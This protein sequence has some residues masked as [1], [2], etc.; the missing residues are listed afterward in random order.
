MIRT[1]RS[2]RPTSSNNR[3]LLQELR[4]RFPGVVAI[5]IV[6]PFTF[7]ESDPLPD[8][9][10]TPV[11]V[12]GVVAK[13]MGDREH[14]PF[15][16]SFLGDAGHGHITTLCPEVSDDIKPFHIPSRRTFEALFDILHDAEHIAS[17]LCK[18][19]V[20]LSRVPDEIQIPRL[21]HLPVRIGGLNVGYFNGGTCFDQQARKKSPT[22][23]ILDGDWDNTDY[24]KPENGGSLRPGVVFECKGHPGSRGQHAV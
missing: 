20:V 19:F 8:P 22:P 3:L 12:A 17:Y 4:R 1:K 21:E 11:I 24:I 13:F 14:H 18:L 23:S 5:T 2:K 10:D 6:A 16:A 7:I 15:G 9:A